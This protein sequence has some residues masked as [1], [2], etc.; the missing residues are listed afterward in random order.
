M[1]YIVRT[2]EPDPGDD[3]TL[4]L[5]WGDTE[6]TEY[7]KDL[8]EIARTDGTGPLVSGI[9]CWDENNQREELEI[10]LDREVREEDGWLDQYYQLRR[11]GTEDPVLS[12]TLSIEE[13]RMA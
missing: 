10:H 6:I 5:L 1:D 8:I 12:F 4:H 2:T 11:K 13:K 7:L 3:L 9:W